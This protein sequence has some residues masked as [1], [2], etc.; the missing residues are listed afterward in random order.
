MTESL[1]PDYRLGDPVTS[2]ECERN[3]QEAIAFYSTFGLSQAIRGDG[4]ATTYRY[5]H[6]P[7]NESVVGT[8]S[9][10]RRAVL[11]H[12]DIIDVLRRFGSRHDMIRLIKADAAARGIIL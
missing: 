6:D 7:T 5:W 12:E 10:G 8:S 1:S 4:D 9:E 11:S 3:A 2:I